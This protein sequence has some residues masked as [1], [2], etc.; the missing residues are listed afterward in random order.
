MSDD[1]EMLI[2][3]VAIWRT[4]ALRNPFWRSWARSEKRR[5]PKNPTNRPAAR[6][7]WIGGLIP[8]K[9]AGSTF[10][11]FF[12]LRYLHQIYPT[13][14]TFPEYHGS[15][16]SM[17]LISVRFRLPSDSFPWKL[18]WFRSQNA[19]F[20]VPTVH[21]WGNS[22]HAECWAKSCPTVR[23]MT[24]VST[25]SSHTAASFHKFWIVEMKERKVPI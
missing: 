25:I 17:F 10:P 19:F 14:P 8:V 6:L 3:D 21:R 15:K 1:V 23:G 16:E 20:C 22:A 24:E 4:D 9:T 13:Y 2:G 12:K 7:T 11:H 5:S 18:S